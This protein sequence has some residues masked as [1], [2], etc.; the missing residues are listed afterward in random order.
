[1]TEANSAGFAEKGFLIHCSVLCIGGFSGKYSRNCQGEPETVVLIKQSSSHWQL[2]H[3]G[4]WGIAQPFV[5]LRPRD[6]PWSV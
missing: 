1:M 2:I 6:I 5:Y 4:R 3:W